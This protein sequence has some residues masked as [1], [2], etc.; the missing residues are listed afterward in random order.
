MGVT[1][2]GNDPPFLSGLWLQPD[3]KVCDGLAFRV[4]ETQTAL[5]IASSFV[6]YFENHD[7]YSFVERDVPGDVI[8]LLQGTR[9]GGFEQ[10]LPVKINFPLVIAPH[11]QFEIGP[12]RFGPN[13]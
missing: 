8:I 11:L 10:E 5:P 9:L 1:R 12:L 7:I 6:E 3:E 2:P 13:V 4:G